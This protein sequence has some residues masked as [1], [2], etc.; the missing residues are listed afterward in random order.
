MKGSGRPPGPAARGATKISP[1]SAT[2]TRESPDADRPGQGGQETR[3]RDRLER[4]HGRALPGLQVLPA[5]VGRRPERGQVGAAPHVRPEARDRV[6]VPVPHRPDLDRAGH[7]LPRTRRSA[8]RIPLISA[9]STATVASGRTSIL[10]KGVP[11]GGRVDPAASG[12]ERRLEARGLDARDHPRRPTLRRGRRRAPAARRGP[13]RDRV[14]SRPPPPRVSSSAQRVRIGW[15]ACA[16]PPRGPPRARARGPPARGGPLPAPPDRDA[17]SRRSISA[18]AGPRIELLQPALDGLPGIP[19]IRWT[20]SVHG[21]RAAGHQEQRRR[22]A[23]RPQAGERTAEV[24]GIPVVEGDR[25]PA[26]AEPRA[27]GRSRAAEHDPEVPS[28]ARRDA[29]RR[30]GAGG[31]GDAGPRVVHAVVAEHHRAS[32]AAQQ[33]PGHPEPLEERADE[34]AEAALHEGG[35]YHAGRPVSP[36]GPGFRVSGRDGGTGSPAASGSRDSAGGGSRSPPA[37]TRRRGSSRPGPCVRSARRRPRGE[38]MSSEAASGG[39]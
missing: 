23:R 30:G 7:H 20:R 18:I 5:V 6:E 2:R 29:S 11:R 27:S 25:R 4:A 39:P 33:P 8:G 34:I 14:G 16:R 13:P 19:G 38:W 17:L 24:V 32:P 21:T 37:T 36:R 31:R 22:D 12:G 15:C 1:S 35:C 3:E 10:G 26:L 28:R 9:A